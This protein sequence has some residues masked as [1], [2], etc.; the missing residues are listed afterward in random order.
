MNRLP[1]P[2]QLPY[3]F[4][5]PR[6]SPFWVSTSRLFVRYMLRRLQ[7]LRSFEFTGVEHLKAVVRKGD[8][9]LITPNHPDY[10]DAGVMF[11]LSRRLGSA[12]LLHGR[13][14]DLRRGRG[15][16]EVPPAQARA[17]SPSTARART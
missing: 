13:L 17:S 9:V 14:P 15:A 6:V 5:P 3:H 7:W 12:V 2:D 10:A 8:G 1:L 16:P 4:H 11:E